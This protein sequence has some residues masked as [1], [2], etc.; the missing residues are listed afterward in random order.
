MSVS[1]QWLSNRNKAI[2]IIG[3]ILLMAGMYIFIFNKS[4]SFI[5]PG[6][7]NLITYRVHGGNVYYSVAGQG[8]WQE[9][10]GIDSHSFK[11]ISD[12][13]ISDKH[14]VF[15]CSEDGCQKVTSDRQGFSLLDFNI[16]RDTASLYYNGTSVGDIAGTLRHYEEREQEYFVDDERV[17]IR[18][19]SAKNCRD[20]LSLLQGLDPKKTEWFTIAPKYALVSDDHDFFYIYRSG[21]CDSGYFDSWQSVSFLAEE[22][23]QKVLED[24]SGNFRAL[25]KDSQDALFSGGKLK[26]GLVPQDVR[27]A[28]FQTE[29]EVAIWK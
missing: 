6:A 8:I 16:A 23:V 11:V 5:V 20:T 2:V 22:D 3:L 7:R 27:Q 14:W 1:F 17:W 24:S 10:E 28:A 29:A 12:N 9:I 25:L 18:A 19:V 4:F 21:R 15:F 13:Y 26:L